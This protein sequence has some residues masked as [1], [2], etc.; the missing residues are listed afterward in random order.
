MRQV[1]FFNIIVDKDQENKCCMFS[2]VK[3]SLNI[4]FSNREKKSNLELSIMNPYMP[5]RIYT[6][7]VCVLMHVPVSWRLECELDGG[8][9][10]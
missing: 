5:T 4:L 3:N 2:V 1:F 6:V 8:G 10:L 7:C 9:K